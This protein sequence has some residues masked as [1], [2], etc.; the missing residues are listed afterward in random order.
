VWVNNPVFADL[1]N[2]VDPIIAPRQTN[3]LYNN[4]FTCQATPV[5]RKY[6]NIPQFTT[7][8]GGAYFF[9]PGIRALTY[10]ATR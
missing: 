5:R 8:I 10:I 1:Y 2:D 3:D 9:L 6:K 7:V 4:D